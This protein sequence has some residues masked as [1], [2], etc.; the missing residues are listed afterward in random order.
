[1]R[2]ENRWQCDKCGNVHKTWLEASRCHKWTTLTK[3]RVV[4]N[5]DGT[6]QR[7]VVKNTTDEDE[8]FGLM[9]DLVGDV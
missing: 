9:S 8:T 3:V 1:M 5:D 6:V 2:F 7:A 4:V